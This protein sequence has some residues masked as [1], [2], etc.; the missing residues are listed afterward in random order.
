VIRASGNCAIDFAQDRERRTHHW[1]HVLWLAKFGPEMARSLHVA[2]RQNK[3][4]CLNN[5]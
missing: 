1:D 3:G 5:R 4:D 2:D